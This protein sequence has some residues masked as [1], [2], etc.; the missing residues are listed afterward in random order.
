MDIFRVVQHIDTLLDRSKLSLGVSRIVQNVSSS[1]SVSIQ[2]VLC[3]VPWPRQTGSKSCSF[4]E[5]R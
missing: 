2:P 5:T 4:F 1:H 3:G